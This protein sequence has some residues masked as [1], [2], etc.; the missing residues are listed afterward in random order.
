MHASPTQER[1]VW[2][3]L[4]GDALIARSRSMQMTKWYDQMPDADVMVTI[5]DDI[6]FDPEDL[7][8]IVEGARETRGIYGGAYVTR[9]Q[10]PH[11]SSRMLPNTPELIFQKTDIRRP[12]EFQ[13]VATGFMAIHRD[14]VE[15]MV[16]GEF[17][18]A[19]GTHRLH[20][21]DKGTSMH[22]FLPFY[23][24]FTVQEPDGSYHWLSEDWAFCERA[25][26]LGFKCW[27]DQSI[28][29]GHVG[30]V[31]FTV[32]DI[33]RS[34][35]TTGHATS[36]EAQPSTGRASA[37]M[38]ISV[39][40][41]GV[42]LIDEL[43]ADIAR[44]ADET[45][46]SIRRGMMHG[47]S[48][49]A[50][51][52]A[53]REDQSEGEWYQREDVGLAYMLDLAQ[54]HAMGGGAPL[55]LAEG[56]SG[57]RVLEYGCGIGTW[58]L[59]AASHGADVTVCDVNATLL[60]FVGWRARER[61]LTVNIAGPNTLG[62]E[63]YDAIVAWHVFEHVEDPGQVLAALVSRLVPGGELITASDFHVDALHPQHHDFTGDW[64]DELRRMGMEQDGIVWR[65][66]DVAEQQQHLASAA[67]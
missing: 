30:Q 15:A 36:A 50:T 16:H 14:V 32:A 53:T 62:F 8:K 44:W 48:K 19:D 37:I 55:A 60:E 35:E 67:V 17:R 46:P 52:W 26:Q 51:L 43:P 28:V 10:T 3:P 12:I 58:G 4:W 63:K 65:K 1:I 27:I 11:L 49:L 13:Y 31:V 9:S 54:W 41:T 64:D 33:K 47:A 20:R 21:C 25:R 18:D 5:D 29:L 66:R 6:Q 56:Y 7:W 24:T 40:H 59:A 39:T 34:G 38:D 42:P 2:E 61:G 23:D 45:E 22:D 57:K